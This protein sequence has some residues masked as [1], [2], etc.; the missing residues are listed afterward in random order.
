M[1][2]GREGQAMELETEFSGYPWHPP[3]KR[4]QAKSRG[5]KS[6]KIDFHAA[7]VVDANRSQPDVCWWLGDYQHGLS[8]PPN[9][10]SEDP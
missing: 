4:E 9:G 1:A 2:Q 7:E 3:D 6:L 8:A 10:V 5:R